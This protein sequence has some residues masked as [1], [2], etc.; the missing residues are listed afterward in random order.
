MLTT[1]GRSQ[2]LIA[3]ASTLL[4]PPGLTGCTRTP[5]QSAAPSASV[6]DQQ[7][8]TLEAPRQQLAPIPPPQKTRSMA[9]RSLTSWE[10]P[11]LTVQG[12]MVTLHVLLADANPS[13]LGQGGMLR[14]IGARRQNLDIRVNDLPTA[15][16]AVP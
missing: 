2:L 7:R 5:A 3:L 11:Y 4:L 1:D 6:T 13:Q 15:L 14:P 16:N 8:Q 10:N 12:G 9:V